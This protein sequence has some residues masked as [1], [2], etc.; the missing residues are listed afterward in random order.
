MVVNSGDIDI[1]LGFGAFSIEFENSSNH[2]GGVVY[3]PRIVD[4]DDDG[5]MEIWVFTWDFWSLA[6][7]EAT[8]SNTYELQV[9]LDKLYEGDEIDFG[10]RR[11]MQFYDVN[12]DGK[13]EFYHSGIVASGAEGSFVF[14]IGSTDDVSTLTTADVIELGGQDLPYAGSAV[15]DLDGDGLMDFLFSGRNL[16]DE[17]GKIHRME[18]KGSGDLAQGASY[19]FSLLYE[20]SNRPT[21]LRNIAIGDFDSDNKMDVIITQPAVSSTEDAILIILESETP[22]SVEKTTEMP[23]EF[24]LSQNYP[25]PFNPTTT[26]EFDI[27]AEQHVSLIVYNILG[28]KVATLVDETRMTGAHK[29][30]FAASTLNSGIYY[31]TLESGGLKSTKKMLVIK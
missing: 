23:T 28:E 24:S 17:G 12:G 5:K 26:I 10:H 8:G 21:D 14:Y 19:E 15:G 30:N 20:D 9:E 13:L 4:F 7:Y 22:L 29:V 3:D 6:I 11:G 16:Y 2:E 1:G 27:K 25:N 31:Y 18:Y